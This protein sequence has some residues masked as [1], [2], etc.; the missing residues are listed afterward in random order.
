MGSP[1]CVV[2]LSVCRGGKENGTPCDQQAGVPGL[3]AAHRRPKM[4]P[5]NAEA[6][7]APP[8]QGILRKLERMCPGDHGVLLEPSRGNT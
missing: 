1:V 2:C 4:S 8:P 6:F 5:S 7:H 3:L